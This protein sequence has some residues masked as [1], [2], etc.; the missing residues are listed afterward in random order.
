MA[1][2]ELAARLIDAIAAQD[3][4]AVGRLLAPDAR[5]RA[6]VPPGVRD[7]EGREAVV[8]RLTLWF[9][10]TRDLSIVESEAEELAG[11]I[12]FRYRLRGREEGAWVVQEQSGYV[13]VRDGTIVA[14]D[15]VCSGSRP[16][17]APPE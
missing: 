10:D 4:A 17:L 6:L 3:F 13:D 5:L 2:V 9:G 8:A 7:D 16:V 12:R 15:L 14:I 1:A 11:R